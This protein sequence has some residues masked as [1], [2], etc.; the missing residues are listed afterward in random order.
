VTQRS[1]SSVWRKYRIWQ[2]YSRR[3]FPWDSKPTIRRGRR[4]SSQQ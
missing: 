1:P 4:K 2:I 3:P